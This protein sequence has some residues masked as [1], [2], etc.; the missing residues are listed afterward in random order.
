MGAELIVYMEFFY[1][2]AEANEQAST[3]IRAAED[4]LD[5][6]CR[7][8]KPSIEAVQGAIITGFIA[9]HLEGLHRYRS[10]FCYCCSISSRLRLHRID[11]ILDERKHDKYSPGRARKADM[12]APLRIRLVSNTY[13]IYEIED[14]IA[15]RSEG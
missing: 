10:L 6:A 12:V 15:D 9:G 8:P 2:P 7:S 5:V 13:D 3:W 14:R 11:Y 1:L 4:V